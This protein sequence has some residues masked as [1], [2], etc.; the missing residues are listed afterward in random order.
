[1]SVDPLFGGDFEEYYPI[2]KS[3]RGGGGTGGQA[4]GSGGG[5]GG[6]FGGVGGGSFGSNVPVVPGQAYGG[7][8]GMMR[9]KLVQM[10]NGAV[11]VSY[12]PL[13][14]TDSVPAML[15]PGEFV[16]NRE[17]MAMPGAKEAVGMLNQAGRVQKMAEGGPVV[18]GG[19]MDPE[20][21]SKLVAAILTVLNGRGGHEAA[22]EPEGFAWGGPV[23]P[24]LSAF[25]Q[26][27]LGGSRTPFQN[28]AS[29]QG[30]QSYGASGARPGAAP[31]GGNPVQALNTA[32]Q[33][34]QQSLGVGGQQGGAQWVPPGAN[35]SGDPTISLNP[36]SGSGW[37]QSR[38]LNQLYGMM[39]QGGLSG[40]FSPEGSPALLASLQ[41]EA[42]Q[43]ADALRKRASL[44]ADVLG[45]DAGQRGSYAMQTDLN[46]QGGVAQ[47]LNAAKRA[48]LENQQGLYQDLMR[49]LGQF[50]MQDWMAERQGDISKRYAPDQ[51]G[52]AWDTLAGLGGA[53]LGGWGASGFRRPW[54]K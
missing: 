5:F 9:R 38:F 17:A 29:G 19:G 49:A 52:S 1:M 22:E 11:P 37:D 12:S 4:P 43:N 10:A 46:T 13:S 50:N 40:M 32:G 24:R 15:T 47:T 41:D 18:G 14:S 3:G 48:Q 26:G 51:G 8:M 45:L 30:W 42:R 2:I 16:V 20:M 21:V 6:G 25:R 27:G 33:R 36:W 7:N 53:A 31:V 39:N 35:P 28:P 54:G 23:N 44:N 34:A